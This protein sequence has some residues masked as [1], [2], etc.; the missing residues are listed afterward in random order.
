MKAAFSVF[1]LLISQTAQ[2]Q[3]DFY[4][5]IGG[6]EP[7][8]RPT[9]VPASNFRIRSN[10]EAGGAYHC[11]DFDFDASLA[12]QMANARDRL[13]TGVVNSVQSLFAALPELLLQRIRPDLYDLFQKLM[14]RAEA[15]V[16]FAFQSCDDWLDASRESDGVGKL[17]RE[18]VSVN[19]QTEIQR[20]GQDIYQA[21]QN[22]NRDPAGQGIRW[23]D[24]EF[25]AGSSGRPLQP[26]MESAIAGYNALIGRDCADRGRPPLEDI[27][28]D[29]PQARWQQLVQQFE[30]PA[31]IEVFVREAVG[32][33]VFRAGS[34]DVGEGRP[35]QG[36]QGLVDRAF[37]EFY[38]IV[39][40]AAFLEAPPYSTATRAEF[41]PGGG[42]LTPDLLQALQTVEPGRRRI[43]VERLSRE[44]SAAK[45][46]DQALQARKAL[47]AARTIPEIRSSDF[48]IGDID[49]AMASFQQQIE[50]L[51]FER[52]VRRTLVNDLAVLII[53]DA[54]QQQRRNT[55]EIPS[56]VTP[57]N[58]EDGGVMD[59]DTP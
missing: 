31:D 30:A 38:P 28:A 50:E 10:F 54:K 48:V 16:R 3:D 53:E 15:D 6:A 44:I 33:N 5:R 12:V 21:Q 40:Q 24:G 18:A 29:N 42:R 32:D 22:I 25:R 14:V 26:V 23:C 49:R 46:I 39:D 11:G 55:S 43:L 45:V 19:W 1:L 35:P 57:L 47:A 37:E 34:A 41:Y 27:D 8:S 7:F 20:N 58:I 51:M 56:N 4:Y 17:F 2:S 9:I 52:T 59:Q 13:R 36:L